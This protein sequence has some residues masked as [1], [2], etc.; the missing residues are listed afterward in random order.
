MWADA[1][2]QARLV[3]RGEVSPLELVESAIDR[4]QTLD[5]S[6]NAVIHTRFE[7]ARSEAAK[8]PPGGAFRGVPVV[9]KDWGCQSIGDPYH[10]GSKF[11]RRLDWHSDHDSILTRKLRSAGFIII[12]RTN[13]SELAMSMTTEPLA[14]GPTH[15]P[16]SLDRTAGGSSG[17]SAAAAAAGFVPVAQASDGG[18]SI[19]IPASWCGLVGLKPSRGRVAAAPGMANDWAG[20]LT[21]GVMTR[22]VRDT[23]AV[24]EIISG[25]VPGTPASL[26][27]AMSKD[28]YRA[29]HGGS[30]R[31]GLLHH[32][33]RDYDDISGELVEAVESTGLLLQE[34]GHKVGHGYPEA[35]DDPTFSENFGNVLSSWCAA[36]VNE[37]VRFTGEKIHDGDLE[38][39]T[40]ALAERGWSLPAVDYIESVRWLERFQSRVTSW[41]TEGGYDL[42]VSPVAAAPAPALG[43]LTDPVTGGGR[44]SQ[45]VQFVRQ[46]NVTGQPAIS[47]PLAWTGDGLPI[48]LQLVAGYGQDGLLL[49]LSAQLEEANPW[50][51]SRPPLTA[52]Y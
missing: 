10:A 26:S 2:E 15:N 13:T 11:L 17:G 8:C 35:L 31:I 43:W 18:G 12:G 4:V 14:Y 38:P 28:S 30:L 29:R 44:R 40:I 20:Y 39:R 7:R 37:M 6:L 36:Q 5:K 25:A 34:M 27:S 41:W 49:E 19:R 21:D 47:L 16:W 23:A 52:G 42:L 22:T 3:D 50:S 33:L 51:L 45:M 48:G 32:S 9:L 46:F 1:T 24:L